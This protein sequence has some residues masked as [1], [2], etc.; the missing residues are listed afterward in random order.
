MSKTKRIQNP[1]DQLITR[2]EC[3]ELIVHDIN[4]VFVQMVDKPEEPTWCPGV[5]EAAPDATTDIPTVSA[6]T[7]CWSQ[8]VQHDVN[9]MMEGVE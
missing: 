1:G 5:A 7:I 3:Q 6:P 9:M 4:Q 8:G 2:R